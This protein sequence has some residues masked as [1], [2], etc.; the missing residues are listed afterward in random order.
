MTKTAPASRLWLQALSAVSVVGQDPAQTFGAV[1]NNLADLYGE[2][3]AL[4]DD[5]CSLSY[6]ELA[7]RANRYGRWAH[8]QGF[9]RGAVIALIMRN[10]AEYVAIWAGLSQAGITVALINTNLGGPAMAHAIRVPACAAAIV[11]AGL[12][13]EF[14]TSNAD[15]PFWIH[16]ETKQAVVPR[17][18]IEAVAY[19]GH[20]PAQLDTAD[21]PALLIYTSGT[22]GLPKAANVSHARVLQWCHWFAG[23]MEIEPKDRLYNCL[24]MYHSTG[25]VCAIGAVLVRGGSVV[26]RRR[27]SRSRFWRDIVITESTIFQYIGELCRYLLQAEPEE[28]ETRH[29]LRLCSGNGLRKN[30]WTEFENRFQIPRILEFY[31][32]TE[33]SVSLYN[34]DGKPGSIGRVPNFLAHRFPLALVR[35]DTDSG[36]YLRG[37]SGY[38]QHC[39]PG[40]IGEALGRLDPKNVV[41]GQ[42]FEGYVDP[43]ASNAKVLRNVFSENDLWYRTGDLLQRDEDGFYYFVD[44][45]GDAFRWKGENISATEVASVIAGCSG[46]V[47][48]VVLG[49]RLPNYEGRAGM[50]AIAVEA[51]FD[52]A[53]FWNEIHER[54]PSYA[55]PVFVRRC[56][57]I[58]RT[59]TFK[60]SSSRLKADGYLQVPVED[61]WFDDWKSKTYINFTAE[62][63]VMLERGNLKV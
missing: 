12:F 51:R 62:L 39:G 30:V 29:R 4:I 15:I 16:G 18:D 20:R 57:V 33:G 1:L 53:K 42:R 21:V 61:L 32:A 58:D 27:F 10:C 45:L 36:E 44:R 19:S 43:A 5:D 24:P 60:L 2:R 63:R 41:A 23:M 38:Y 13:E 3:V 49:V 40:E 9:R 26:I 55:R 7:L 34:C 52:I 28:F 37:D 31:A 14:E 48:A 46:V 56:N 25:G 11:E 22:T 8:A 35:C 54:L 47:D 6:Q 59:P 50:T 17:I